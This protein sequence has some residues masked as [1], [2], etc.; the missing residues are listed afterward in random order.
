MALTGVRSIDE[1]DRRVLVSCRQLSRFVSE[2]VF[3]KNAT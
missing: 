2:L 3:D 1:I